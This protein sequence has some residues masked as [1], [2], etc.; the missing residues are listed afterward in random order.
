MNSLCI[1]VQSVFPLNFNIYFPYIASSV[2]LVKNTVGAGVFSLS[3]RVT[4]ISPEPAT[5]GLAVALIIVMA[6]W[7]TY[8]FW[9]LGKSCEMTN[10]TTYA[11]VW[12]KTVSKTSSWIVQGVTVVAPIVSCLAS[13]IV[14]TGK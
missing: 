11:E 8:N 5:Q 9:A 6:S 1:R 12:S 2:N 10:S 4:A 13:S 3:S 7:A 14:L